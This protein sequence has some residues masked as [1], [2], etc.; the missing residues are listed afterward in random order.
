MHKNSPSPGGKFRS[1]GEN[2]GGETPHLPGGDAC[3]LNVGERERKSMDIVAFLS[4]FPSCV[5]VER[6]VY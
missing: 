6:V 1:N 4:E 2:E 3:A 5:G